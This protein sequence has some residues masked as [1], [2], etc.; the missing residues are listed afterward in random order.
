MVSGVPGDVV[1]KADGCERD[2]TVIKRIQE[3]PSGLKLGE[4]EGWEHDEQGQGDDA[5]DG[6]VE[7]ADV[8]G[9]LAGNVAC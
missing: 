8:E 7:H 1:S 5:H 2:E 4:Y 9:L 6:Q 3:V